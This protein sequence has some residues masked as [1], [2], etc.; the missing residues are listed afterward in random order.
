MSESYSPGD[1]ET[2][3]QLFQAV[4]K[5][6]HSIRSG[7]ASQ[8]KDAPNLYD[9]FTRSGK[10]NILEGGQRIPHKFEWNEDVL[11][12]YLKN[13]Q[14]YIPG[15]RC[16]F[17]TAR[18]ANVW[19]RNSLIT[20]LKEKPTKTQYRRDLKNAILP[21]KLKEDPQVVQAPKKTMFQSF[22]GIFKRGS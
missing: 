12:E 18:V 20:Y 22:M 1:Y 15:T 11:F 17:K 4:C 2:G 10:R 19:D 13:P 8:N 21:K 6:C 16:S 7:E 3:Q 5:D 9:L 14:K